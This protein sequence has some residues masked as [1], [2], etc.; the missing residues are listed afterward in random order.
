MCTVLLPSGVNPIAV[1]KYISIDIKVSEGEHFFLLVGN[2]NSVDLILKNHL[3]YVNKIK[4][5][6]KC[7][8]SFLM[9]AVKNDCLGKWNL[10]T[11]AKF[12]RYGFE[13]NAIKSN[14]LNSRYFDSGFGAGLC[15]PS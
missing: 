13:R 9:L 15:Y 7:L 12:V 8:C 14:F 2:T 10:E 3:A 5:T 11:S 1:N 6:R 4:M